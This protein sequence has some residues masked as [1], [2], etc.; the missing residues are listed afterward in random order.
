MRAV[1]RSGLL[2]AV[3]I[4]V[5]TACLDRN[6]G[7]DS[8]VQMREDIAT[9]DAYLASKNITGYLADP[10]GIRFVFSKVGTKGFPARVDQSIKVKYKGYYL[11]GTVFDAGTT[12]AEGPLSTFII[13]WQY[14]M[15]SLP[16]GTQGQLFVPSPIAYGGKV[17]G[18]IPANSILVFDIDFQ[19][20]S[21]TNAE[22]AQL[23]SDSTAIDTYLTAQSIPNVTKDTTGVRYVITQQG[24]GVPAGYY[25]AVTFTATGKQLSNSNQ[26]YSGTTG[27]TTSFGSRVV[28]YIHGLQVPLMKVGK[29]GK[30][31]A[32]IPSSL[33]FGPFDNTQ[34]GLPANSNVIYEVEVTD[35][36]N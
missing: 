17:R 36:T 20:V 33:A 15:S 16:A 29:G 28:D 23:K 24:T 30:F 31:T 8:G 13:G 21:Y 10:A 3:L 19:E 14:A 7:V 25:S 4:G 32:Y 11:D 9:I 5:M 2:I 26:F 27:P 18:T 34:T 12:L 1:R 6:E 22:K 35:I